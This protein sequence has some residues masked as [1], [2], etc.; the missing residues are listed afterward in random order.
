MSRK[1]KRSVVSA[2]EKRSAEEGR[3]GGFGKRFEREGSKENSKSAKGTGGW[4]GSV[5]IFCTKFQ[6]DIYWFLNV[7]VAQVAGCVT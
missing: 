6:K 3:G 4:R 1:P 2:G 7:S 5:D